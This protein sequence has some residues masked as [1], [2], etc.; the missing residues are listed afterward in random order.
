[1]AATAKTVV[2]TGASSGL[3]FH[4][5][6]HLLSQTSQPYLFILGARDVSRTQDAYRSAFQGAALDPH[7]LE[8]LPLQ[9]SDLK[10]VKHFAKQTLEKLEGKRIDYLLLNA[11]ITNGAG[12]EKPG[13]GGSKWCEALVVNHLSQHYLSHLLL[14]ALLRPGSDIAADTTA[15]SNSRIV[16]VS[17]GA[18][19]R[20]TD[21]S[22]LEED[23]LAGSGKDG[24]TVYAETKFVQLLGAH[25]WR[26]KLKDAACKVVAVSP[27]LIPGTG[28]G[29]G[30]GLVLSMEMKD[31]KSVDEGAQSILRAFTRDDFPEDP[32]R[33]FLTSWGE[34]W[35]SE[36]IGKTL[37]KELQDRWCSEKEEIETEEGLKDF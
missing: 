9:L 1:M 13:P 22:T 17:S 23:L 36:T 18:I 26:R 25:W 27:G 6:K 11:G 5:I 3:G 30:S 10:S 2:A 29:R 32:N 8:I 33:I 28:I 14:P 16:V 7:S 19:R 31:A 12:T 35:E 34:W 20:V 24:N 21:P 4:V 37:N 15:D